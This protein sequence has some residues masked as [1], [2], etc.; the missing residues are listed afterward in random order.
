VFGKA[1]VWLIPYR[2]GLFSPWGEINSSPCWTKLQ[3]S[4]PLALPNPSLLRNFTLT[5]TLDHNG[6]QRHPTPR[7]GQ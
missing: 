6:H 2:V 4:N 3:H 1:L 7:L 5:S